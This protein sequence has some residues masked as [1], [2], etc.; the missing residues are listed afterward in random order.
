MGIP[1][2]PSLILLDGSTPRS[3]IERK[4]D[5]QK[6]NAHGARRTG[7][8]YPGQDRR[9]CGARGVRPSRW[10]RTGGDRLARQLS[11]HVLLL[12]RSEDQAGGAQPPVLWRRVRQV[13]Q[14]HP[15]LRGIRHPLQLRPAPAAGV[16]IREA[17]RRPAP[18]QSQARIVERAAA[19]LDVAVER[20]RAVWPD[21]RATQCGRGERSGLMELRRLEPKAGS[22]RGCLVEHVHSPCMGFRRCCL[23]RALGASWPSGQS[24]TARMCEWRRANGSDG[25]STGKCALDAAT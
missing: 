6:V 22:G 15:L 20:V 5:E 21:R 24:S 13:R 9:R 8:G 23:G 25:T 18:C 10:A 11:R 7:C 14:D 2:L 17:R 3:R 12:N 4:S 19:G 16:S 1:A